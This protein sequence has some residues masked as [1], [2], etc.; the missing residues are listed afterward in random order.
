MVTSLAPRQRGLPHVMPVF[1]AYSLDLGLIN[2]E[3]CAAREYAPLIKL[4]VSFPEM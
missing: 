2:L 4:R 3:H 1:C